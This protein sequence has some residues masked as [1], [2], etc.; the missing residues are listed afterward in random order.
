MCLAQHLLSRLHVPTISCFS[1]VIISIAEPERKVLRGSGWDATTIY[2]SVITWEGANERKTW[3]IRRS[4]IMGNLLALPIIWWGK[5]LWCFSFSCKTIW[6][7][8]WYR[9]WKFRHLSIG[10]HTYVP[11]SETGW[12]IFLTYIPPL[13]THSPSKLWLITSNY[14]YLGY[15]IP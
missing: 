3:H 7:Q 10:C 8:K 9:L 13:D 2:I 11:L 6:W 5:S 15:N 1:K 12:C 14:N 4:Q